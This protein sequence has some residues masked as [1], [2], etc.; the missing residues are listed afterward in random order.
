MILNISKIMN[1][2]DQIYVIN[3]RKRRDR[4][5]NF[6][7]SV[8]LAFIEKIKIVGGIDGLNH[9]LS[10][11]E[12]K[13]LRNAD[14][15]IEKRRGILGCSFSHELVWRSIIEKGQKNAIILEDDAVFQFTE[16]DEFLKMIKL[17][18][19]QICFLG[20]SNHPENIDG[21][22]DFTELV[23]PKICKMKS[24][25]G[26][27]SYLITLEGAKALVKIIDDRG[28]YRAVDQII[29][30]Y[31]KQIQKWVCSAPPL[32]SVADLG[33]DIVSA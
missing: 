8:P 25:L 21:S 10:N 28:H 12:M 27:M 30:D 19:I 22:H 1:N 6:I 9:V 24:N 13:K 2:I 17:L 23:G 7:E 31:M 20:P 16:C 32:F 15:D 18:D 5:A 3:L 29:N 14:W 4:I 33:S 11:D 26:S